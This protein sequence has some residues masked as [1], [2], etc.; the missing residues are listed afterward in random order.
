[1]Q[2]NIPRLLHDVSLF[3]GAIDAKISYEVGNASLFGSAPQICHP[4]LAWL[5]L[6]GCFAC[7][8]RE[9][10]FTFHEEAHVKLVNVCPFSSSE[11]VK[12]NFQEFQGFQNETFLRSQIVIIVK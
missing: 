4:M 6:L 8:I 10:S 1:M 11:L 2:E 12:L 3:T 5:I 9:D 7:R